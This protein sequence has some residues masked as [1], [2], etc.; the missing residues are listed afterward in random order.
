MVLNEQQSV[1]QL[2]DD[3]GHLSGELAEQIAPRMDNG[4]SFVAR[5]SAVTGDL[6][7][8]AAGDDGYNA[9]LNIYIYKVT[10]RTE[11]AKAMAAARL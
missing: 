1:I 6:E 11:L 8:D 9:G 2:C 4:E 7:V 5:I 3:L 10:E